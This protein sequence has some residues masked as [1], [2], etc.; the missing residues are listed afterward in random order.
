MTT[1]PGRPSRRPH[2]PTGHGDWS[3]STRR[4]LALYA[5]H[6]GS[7]AVPASVE[8][9]R[10]DPA[11]AALAGAEP[12][13][14]AVTEHVLD[15]P[16]RPLPAR[17]YRPSGAE[18]SGPPLPGIVYFHG[19]GFVVGGL[20]SHHGWVAALA[21]VTGRIV[22][23]VDYRLAPEHPFPAASEDA[24][25]AT[26]HLAAHAWDFGIDPA[27]LAVA[28]DSAG[29][30]LAAGVAQ[31]AARADLRLD[32]QILVVPWLTPV[33]PE[34]SRTELA[35]GYIITDALL[36]WFLE[37][38][39]APAQYGD[40]LLNPGLAADLTGLAPATVVT[41]ELDPLRDE[42]TAY[43]RRLR[44]A[45]VDAHHHRLEGAVHLFNLAGAVGGEVIEAAADVIAERLRL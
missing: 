30:N 36:S 41:A 27:H 2:E 10:T 31:R 33:A 21:E 43:V 15:T 23:A 1:A 19:G 18:E 28:G 22:V 5:A 8:A 3:S 45:G 4:A 11:V 12:E 24:H 7:D 20:G 38:Y 25:A 9:A 26:L 13:T 40:P 42:G 29:A 35:T 37:H 39:A 16:G 6:G 44:T 14:G 17:V 34:P 32:H